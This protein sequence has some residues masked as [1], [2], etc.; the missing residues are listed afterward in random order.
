MPG[1]EELEV[2]HEAL[3]ILLRQERTIRQELGRHLERAFDR[4]PDRRQ[5]TFPI[6][7]N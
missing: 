7:V 4:P 6:S 3:A 5:L 1:R 2:D